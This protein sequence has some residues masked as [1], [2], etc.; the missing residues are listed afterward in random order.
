MRDLQAMDIVGTRLS[1]TADRRAGAADGIIGPETRQAI[2]TFEAQRQLHVT[3]LLDPGTVSALQA[4][5]G[6][7]APGPP[8]PD[9]CGSR[10]PRSH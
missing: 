10:K 3:G 9:D 4:S 2:Q 1:R 8:Q 5:C 7:A 6:G